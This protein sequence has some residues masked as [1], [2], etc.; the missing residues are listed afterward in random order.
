MLDEVFKD[1]LTA[2]AKRQPGGQ[3]HQP[4]LFAALLRLWDGVC[5]LYAG[6]AKPQA[7]VALLLRLAK[8]FSPEARSTGADSVASE[9]VSGP[10]QRVQRLW[11]DLA[12]LAT[13]RQQFET[14]DVEGG[15]TE[16]G[17]APGE[18]AAKRRRA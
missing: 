17:S 6:K 3:L 18:R 7:W 12:P 9:L 4:Q 2:L 13:I 11:R 16:G 14:A 5:G 15:S 8:L 1:G 10:M